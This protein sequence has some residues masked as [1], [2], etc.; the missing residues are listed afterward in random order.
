ML[1]DRLLAVM[2]RY[3]VSIPMFVMTSPATDAETREYFAA[4]DRCGLAERSVGDFSARDDASG[5]GRNGKTAARKPQI[6]L[7]SQPRWPRRIGRG[8]REERLLGRSGTPRHRALSSTL[9]STIR[10]CN[11]CDP[12]LI[13][14]HVLSQSQVTTQVVRK[15]FAKEKVGNVVGIDGK[16]QIIE[17]S[18]LPDAAAEQFLADGSLKLWAG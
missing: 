3:N 16:V 5:R 18:D 13:G 17:Y 14:Y 1:A 9:K 2:K 7:P 10:S 4:N 12:E 6:N 11:L 15:R 8:S